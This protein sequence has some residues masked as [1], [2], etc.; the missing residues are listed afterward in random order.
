MG[1]LSR[2]VFGVDAKEA[3]FETRGFWGDPEV[4]SRLESIAA[5][6]LVGYHAALEDPRPGPLTRRLRDV[7]HTAR[8][9]AYE[10]AGMGVTVLDSLTPWRAPRRLRA[11]LADSAGPYTYLVHV[12]AGWAL[13]R[14][15]LPVGWL[16]RRLDPLLGWL[17]LDGFG[18]HEGFFHPDHTLDKRGVPSRLKG[19]ARRAFD[20]G[21]GR[22]LWFSHAAD[23][24][25][26]V[27]RLGTFEANRRS[28]LWSGVGLAATYAGFVSRDDLVH[29]RRSAGPH[30]AALA[31]GS[32]FAAKA[33]LRAG[34][35]TPAMTLAC[36]VLCESGPEV[37]AAVTDHALADLP[38]GLGLDSPAPAFEVWRMRI[39]QRWADAGVAA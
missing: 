27:A 9:W 18:F 29:L 38:E 11:V 31:Q 39:Q 10:G 32:A 2:R 15:H 8:G 4:C 23:V 6:F 7:P 21:V 19:Y 36:E 22:S 24:E 28:D 3:S 20:Q 25:R 26:V 16:L 37:A 12:G 30:R 17:A 13:A 5:T 34:H 14:L 33:R 1:N 35:P